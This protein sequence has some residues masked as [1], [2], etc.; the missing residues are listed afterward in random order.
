MTSSIESSLDRPCRR[1]SWCRWHLT[2]GRATVSRE[3]V[4]PDAS[5][6][7]WFGFGSFGAPRNKGALFPPHRHRPNV[8]SRLTMMHLEILSIRTHLEFL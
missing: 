6:S 7:R 2:T 4:S 5:Y 1:S 8:S 3:T